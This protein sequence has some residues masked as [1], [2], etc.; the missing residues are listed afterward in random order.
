MAKFVGVIGYGEAG[1]IRPGVYDDVITEV[2][3]Q[4]DVI[5]NSRRLQEGE[6]VNNDL[7]VGNS[8][9][10][11]ADQFANEH[12]FAIRYVSWA[13]TNWVVSNVEVQS[14]RLLLRLGG[15]YNGPT[16]S[17]PATP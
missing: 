13:G 4:G 12:F 6:K 5:R 15:V 8:I 10:I 14:P 7:S 3:Y 2:Q 11:V 9:S 1:E 17:A 16:A